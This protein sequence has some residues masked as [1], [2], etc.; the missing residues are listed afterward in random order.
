MWQRGIL[1]NSND[2][3]QEADSRFVQINSVLVSGAVGKAGR[4]SGHSTAIS[5]KGWMNLLAALQHSRGVW[6][7]RVALSGF[8]SVF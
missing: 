4:T 2:R 3:L 7:G 8:H 6:C 5:P 1:F